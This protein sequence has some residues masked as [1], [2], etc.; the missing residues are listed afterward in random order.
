VLSG[1]P[2]AIKA[3][4]TAITRD[5]AERVLPRFAV[6]SM[7]AI[8]RDVAAKEAMLRTSP[9]KAVLEAA[10][11]SVTFVPSPWIADVV[12]VP[13]VALRPFIVPTDYRHTAVF[14]CSVADESLGDDAAAPTRRLVKIAAA[15][16]DEL[17]LRVLRM[18]ADEDMNASEIADRL[19]VDRTSLH[20]HLG[21]LR[22]AGLLAIRDEGARGW[23][24]ALR[25]EQLAT[26]GR[27]LQS[28]VRPGRRPRQS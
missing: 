23:R 25:D 21:T 7:A 13:T 26:V 10:T 6:D 4:M 11:N 12:I 16:G 14:V 17:R 3:E 9:A 24:Y 2:D 18:L 20:H 19:G 28:Y 8:E 22:S 15:L 27:E 5:W 1:P